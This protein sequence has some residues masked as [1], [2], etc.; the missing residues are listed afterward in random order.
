MENVKLPLSGNPGIDFIFRQYKA[1]PSGGGNVYTW[2]MAKTS[3]TNPVPSTEFGT[4]YIPIP[5]DNPYND[6]IRKSLSNLSS[7]A[8]VTF[9][10]IDES[11]SGMAMPSSLRSWIL[12]SFFGEIPSSSILRRYPRSTS[13]IVMSTTRCIT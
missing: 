12:H 6:L 3:Y 8:N 4:T 1:L 9:K 11:K 10:E 7:F 2:S 13:F 5:A